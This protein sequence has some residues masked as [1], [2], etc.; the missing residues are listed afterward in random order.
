MLR[1]FV[2][3]AFCPALVFGQTRQT[4]AVALMKSFYSN[5]WAVH[6]VAVR[7]DEF[8]M[9]MSSG[10]SQT[11]YDFAE[12]SGGR[13]RVKYKTNEGEALAVSDGSSTWKA[14][15]KAKQ[16]TVFSAAAV[17]GDDDEEDAAPASRP[18]DLREDAEYN[19]LRRYVTLA[20]YADQAQP[21]KEEN[22]KL[23]GEK[24]RCQV[25]RLALPAG[26]QELWIDEH[27]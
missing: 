16:W 9:T 10:H 25:V 13:Y 14:L 3:I 1:G 6:I 4:D 23:G 5:L 12:A 20:R 21:S 7:S 26:M 15:P 11:E 24:L 17:Q 19:L 18:K 22:V 27:R 8:A 2:F